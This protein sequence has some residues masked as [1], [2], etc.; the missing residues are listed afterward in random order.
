[1]IKLVYSIL[2]QAVTEGAS[3]IHFEPERG[4]TCGSASASTASSTRPP[5]CRSGWSP[6]SSRAMKIMS[7]LDIAEKRVPAGRPRRGQR[8]GPQG[9]PPRRHRCRPS[10]ARARRSASSTRSQALRTLDELGMDG[11][12][13]EPLRGGVHASPTARSSSPARPA[14]ASRP[15]STR[16]SNELNEVDEEH[17]HDRGPGRVPDRRDQPDRRQPQGR[18]RLRHRPALDAARRP[19]HD[20]GRRD[21]RRRDGADRD[22]GGADR[23][24][25]ADDAAHQRRPGR[26]HP[27]AE[28]GDRVA[29]SPPRRSTASSPSGSRGRS[30]R[31][32]SGAR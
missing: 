20:H 27:P 23:P 25:G 4:A 14:R 17:H 12:G 16:R 31:T 3:D 29:S 1:M 7:E 19:R 32:A 28:D 9:R 15:R 21:P 13:R 24:H 8:R 18:A 6:A 26:D 22:R 30:A 11:D 5:A 10:A 2:G